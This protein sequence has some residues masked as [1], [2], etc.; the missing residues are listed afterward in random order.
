MKAHLG[1]DPCQVHFD[2]FV[3]K[4]QSQMEV[5]KWLSWV[6]KYETE[7]CFPPL[8]YS[9]PSPS[10]RRVLL[11]KVYRSQSPWP[12][13]K[14]PLAKSDFELKVEMDSEHLLWRPQITP[15][16]IKP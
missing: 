3:I 10:Y 12:D 13:P 8:K 16:L 4:E 11:L 15:L 2:V 7:V 1:D 14:S 5:I 6:Q 9:A